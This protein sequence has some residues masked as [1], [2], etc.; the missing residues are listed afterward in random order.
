MEELRRMGIK[1]LI[2]GLGFRQVSRRSKKKKHLPR[3]NTEFHG[4]K[5]KQKHLPRTNTEF[6]GRKTL[7]SEPD[8]SATELRRS[9]CHG[10]TRNFTEGRPS[11]DTERRHFFQSRMRERRLL[12]CAGVYNFL[13]HIFTSL[14]CKR[15]F[16]KEAKHF[17]REDAKTAKRQKN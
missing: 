8:A 5:T 16:L 9:I 12:P 4:R 10:L 17:Y 15:R 11:R 1:A 7:H 3:I 6:H 13:L 14:K 2:R